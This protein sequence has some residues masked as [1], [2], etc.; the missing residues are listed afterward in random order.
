MSEA[1]SIN[2]HVSFFSAPLWL[3]REGSLTFTSRLAATQTGY[4][5]FSHLMEDVLRLRR[6]TVVI[7]GSNIKCHPHALRGPLRTCSC[8]FRIPL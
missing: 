3:P 4:R 2:H 6:S 8:F 5:A 1:Q 7:G